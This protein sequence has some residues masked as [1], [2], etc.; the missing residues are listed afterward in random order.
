MTIR[1][2]LIANRGEIAIRIA[3]TAADLGIESIAIFAADDARSLHV[4]AADMAVA[5]PGTGVR[6]YLDIEAVIAAAKAEG[7]DA[8]HPGYGFLAENADFAEACAAAGTLFIGPGPEALRR[9]G[10][11]SEAL[12]LARSAG[13]PVLPASPVITSDADA[14]AFFDEHGPSMVKAVAGG[15]GRGMR[16]AKTRD[17]VVPSLERCRSEARTA[18]GDERVYLERAVLAARHVE[19]QIAGDTGG[20]VTHLWERECTVQRRNQKL[21]EVA[22]APALDDALRRALIEAAVSLGR[23]GGLTALATIEFLVDRERGSFAF[24]EANPRLQVEHTVTEE[25][26]G[27]DLVATQIGLASGAPLAELGL[28][29]PPPAPRGYAIELRLNAE[30]LGADGLTAQPSDGT[31]T[32]FEPPFGPGIRVDG[33]AYAGYETNPNYDPLLAK[34]IVTSKAGDFAAATAR[35]AR[36]LAGF[37]IEGAETNLSLLRAILADPAFA[38]ADVTTAWFGENAARLA[39]AETGSGRYFEGGA[40]AAAQAVRAPVA[41]PEGTEAAVAPLRGTIVSIDVAEGDRVAP[42]QQLA[43][44]EAMKMEHVVTAS[45]AGEV[46][47]LAASVGETLP[48]GAALLFLLPQEGGGGIAATEEDED[49]DRIRAD[50]A[51]LNTRLGYGLDENRPEAV[52]RRRKNNARTVR[53]NVEDLCDPG[54]FIEYGAL[55]LAAQR[56]RRKMEELIPMSPGDGMVCGLGQVNGA[57]FDEEKARTAV[58]AYDYSVFAGTQGH[59]NHK[60]TDRVLELAE[61]A[62]LPVVFFTEGGGGRP[63]DT[64]GAGVAGLDVPTFHTY[65][66]LSGLA[67]R[68]AINNGRCFAGN[69]ALFGCA[70]ITIATAN[71]TIGMGGPAMIEGGGLGVFTPEEVGPMDIQVPNGVVD[72]PV[73]DEAEAVSVAKQVLGYFQGPLTQWSAT[74]QRKLRFAIP[75]NRLRVYDIRP[76]IRDMADEGSFVELKEHNAIGVVTGFVRIEGRP[77][78]LIANNSKHLGGAL[79]AEGSE[80]AAHFLQLCDAFDLPILSL[81]DTP[82]FMVGPDHERESAVR[83]V[84]RLFTVGANISVPLFCVV[85]RKG[86]GLGAQAMA[87]GSFARN[88]FIISWP[89]GEFG[90]MGLEGA[91]KLGYRKE[92]A[93]ETDP[94]KQQALYNELVGRMYERG[95]AISMASVLEIDAVIDPMETRDWV[96]R[97]LKSWPKAPKRDGKKYRF[98]DT[99]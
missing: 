23:A 80:K 12:A 15:G 16:L 63:G 67:P 90:G 32:A 24:I 60:K 58:L 29:S 27:V 93:A 98:I 55:V 46:H 66:K 64:D 83:K 10:D 17:E 34:L 40:P 4:K 94:E 8:I 72:I 82:G 38:S 39:A 65:A 35:A 1:R 7:A 88:A 30:K 85:L 62:Q 74:D 2:L 79:D 70:D 33:S 25:V 20:N 59:M 53:E 78:G 57:S 18:F 51:E 89:T 13:V 91:V 75:E 92:L 96:V 49:L 14:L 81:C 43:V 11:K 86:Y 50:L 56:R 36:A 26:T 47:S 68:I 97:G 42:G 69:A 44:L 41:T 9:F 3:R 22:P 48:E 73:A 45:G 54:S 77:M 87:G 61:E 37:R 52:A 21:I 99:W 76:I 95:K 31:L 5:L 84:S 71:S 28:A 19:V 6:A